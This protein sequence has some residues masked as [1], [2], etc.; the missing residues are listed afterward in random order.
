MPARPRAGAP[1]FVLLLVVLCALAVGAAA[2]AIATA[3]PAAS[4]ANGPGAPFSLSGSIATYSLLAGVGVLLGVVLY[5]RLTGPTV[6][7]PNRF[8]VTFLIVLLLASIFVVVG[9]LVVASGAVSGGS[10]SG[11]GTSANNSTHSGNGSNGTVNATG[12]PL[13]P[14]HV[15]FLPW[16]LWATV[17]GLAVVLA[18]IAVPQTREVL[19]GW[20]RRAPRDHLSAAAARGSLERAVRSVEA[21]EDPRSVIIGLYAELLRQLGRMVG[22]LDPATP[23]EIRAQHLVRLG[24]LPPTAEALTRLF[25]E[26]KYSSHPM[27]AAAAQRAVRVMRAAESDLDRSSGA[28]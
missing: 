17:V 5:R 25:E 18:V 23:E 12:T 8:V 16:V 1:T 15:L 27:D 2:S 21:G 7:V 24:I 26:A 11:A 22:D 3:V 19:A 28:A 4:T 9:H 20:F 14:F 6:P 13:G 10:G